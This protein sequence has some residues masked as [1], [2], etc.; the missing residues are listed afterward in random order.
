MSACIL[1]RRYAA[2]A[3]LF[4]LPAS[5]RTHNQR[6]SAAAHS[7]THIEHAALARFWHTDVSRVAALLLCWAADGCL[8]ELVHLRGEGERGEGRAARTH[9]SMV[10]THLC[11]VASSP[12]HSPRTRRVVFL[13]SVGGA[14]G[15]SSVGSFGRAR[16]CADVRF[17]AGW[18]R[19][20]ETRRSVPVSVG[21]RA[22]PRVLAGAGGWAVWPPVRC[23]C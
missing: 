23:A 7:H 6:E 8:D 19:G 10:C 11:V 18:M 4:L 2:V 3:T 21:G 13:A 15:N 14:S 16:A 17:R 5:A 1:L 20:A 9:V 22:P 12:V